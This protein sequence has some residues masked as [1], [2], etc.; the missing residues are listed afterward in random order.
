MRLSPD[1]RKGMRTEFDYVVVGA[2]SAGCVLANRLSEDPTTTVALLESGG[3]DRKFEIKMPLGYPKLFKTE[4]DWNFT[5]GKQ[6]GLHDRQLYWPRGRVLGGS[7]SLNGQ[8]WMRGYR[9]DYDDW[10][11]PGWSYDEVLPY[12]QRA[13]QRLDGSRDGT[14][15]LPARSTSQICAART[16][17]QKRSCKPVR[18]WAGRG[19]KRSTALT[20]TASR[21][22]R[23]PRDAD[24]GGARPT[25]IYAQPCVAGTSPC[26]PTYRSRG[27]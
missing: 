19:W 5:T 20:A 1:K 26:S 8:I 24:G 9:T 22:R 12:F 17:P 27:C 4:Y 13:E 11:V 14:Y 3:S 23:S 2:G 6:V 25:P 7:S 15:G 21:Q 10:N 18:S 16:P